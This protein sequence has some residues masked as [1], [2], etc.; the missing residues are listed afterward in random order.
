MNDS[1][2]FQQDTPTPGAETQTQAVTDGLSPL[3]PYTGVPSY[4]APQAE[5]ARRK[6]DEEEAIDAVA[7]KES[8]GWDSFYAKFCENQRADANM[9][10]DYG[11]SRFLRSPDARDEGK[12][13]AYLDDYSEKRW[14]IRCERGNAWTTD[15]TPFDNARQYADAMVGILHR[16]YSAIASPEYNRWMEARESGNREEMMRL[17]GIDRYERDYSMGGYAAGG[18]VWNPQKKSDDE[19]DE[20]LKSYNA[21][22]EGQNFVGVL[23]AYDDAYRLTDEE[24][25]IVL[26][27]L[28]HGDGLPQEWVDAYAGLI[29]EDLDR[30]A[31]IGN[32]IDLTRQRTP[33]WWR[34]NVL[35]PFTTGFKR[36]RDGLANFG[37]EVFAPGL[38][39]S[40]IRR[41]VGENR[42]F[43]WN[44]AERAEYS[45]LYDRY[46]SAL[47]FSD[48]AESRATKVVDGMCARRL[49]LEAM[50]R[51]RQIRERRERLML[52]DALM[53]KPGA[54]YAYWERAIAGAVSTLPYMATLAIPYA[55]FAANVATQFEEVRDDI[56]AGGGD[57]DEAVGAQAVLA[58]AWAGIEKLQMEGLFGRPL[59]G[60]QRKTLLTHVFETSMKDGKIGLIGKYLAGAAKEAALSAVKESVEEGLQDA[61]EGAEREWFRSHDGAKTLDA[62]VTQGWNGFY[63]SLGTMGI[64]G[65]FGA[66]KKSVT[67]NRDSLSNE[68]IADYAAKELKG[69]NVFKNRLMPADGRTLDENEEEKLGKRAKAMMDDCKRIADGH[70]QD[71]SGLRAALDEISEKYGLDEEKLRP[72]GDYLDLRRNLLDTAR[73][74]D[75]DA[76]ARAIAAIAG[77]AFRIGN[78]TTYDPEDLITLLSPNATVETVEIDDPFAKP[79]APAESEATQRL[80]EELANADRR[81]AAARVGSER[82]AA[83]RDRRRIAK[84]LKASEARD[85][86][87]AEHPKAT[88][89]RVTIPVG[90]S[91]ETRSFTIVEQTDAPDVHTRGF[92]A[93]VAEAMR[94]AVGRKNEDG[95][96]VRDGAKMTVDE[97]LELPSAERGATAVTEDQ[98]MALS[99]AERESYLGANKLKT[100]GDFRILDATGREVFGSDAMVSVM[101]AF[102]SPHAAV[103]GNYTLAHEY[104]HA[105]TSFAR[106]L[107]LVDDA[108]AAVMR[109]LFGDPRRGVD[110]LWN[111]EA[112]SNGFSEYLRGE[113][114][115][116]RYTPEE[117]RAAM[118]LFERIW[119]VIKAIFRLN[120][121]R[122]PVTPHERTRREEAL[123]AAYEAIRSG[124]FAG[125]SVYAGIDFDEDAQE[126]KPSGTKK[127]EAEAR[128][129]ADTSERMDGFADDESETDATEPE[130]EQA[131]KAERDERTAGNRAALQADDGSE[132]FRRGFE[133]ALREAAANPAWAAAQPVR[134]G[135]KFTV[136]TPDYQ[137]SVEAEPMWT[138]LASLRESTGDREVQ[139]RDR[140]REASDEQTLRMSRP[141]VFYPLALFP[142]TVSDRGAPIVG[143]GLNIIS[144]HGRK[145][146]LEA[147]AAEG[148]FS[149]YLDAINAEC[150]RQGL[151]TAPEGMENPVL[152]LRVTGG[153][154]SREK[155]VE[156][157]ERSN[158]SNMLERSG[159]EFAE[160][161][162]RRVTPALMR[163]YRPDASGNL[164]A[165]SNRPFMGAFLREV[166]ATGLTNADGTP[167]A[168]A[169]LRV[170]RALMAAVFGSDERVR[171][172]VRSLVERG[173]EL[174][175]SGLTNALMRSA[176]RL[177][178]MRERRGSFD[179]TADVREAA[180]LYIAW[181]SARQSDPRLTLANGDFFGGASPV[182]AA[183]ARLLEAG[184]FGETLEKYADL[185]AREAEDAQGMLGGIA[186]RRTPLQLLCLAERATLPLREGATEARSDDD[187]AVPPVTPDPNTPSAAEPVQSPPAVSLRPAEKETAP[188]KPAGGLESGDTWAQTPVSRK[189]VGNGEAAALDAARAVLDNPTPAAFVP[190]PL[191]R[192]TATLPGANANGI[193]GYEIREDGEPST[194]K[195]PLPPGAY[196][197]LRAPYSVRRPPAPSE[198]DKAGRGLGI[199]NPPP[200]AD[201]HGR[202]WNGIFPAFMGHKTEMADRTS[203]AIRNVMSSAEREHYTTVVDY[204]GGGG[205]W[206]L[207][208]AL[209]NFP[210][211]NRLLVN[212][213]DPDRLEKI[214]LLHEI[215]GR[216]ADEAETILYNP[217]TFPRIRDL[218]GNSSSPSTVAAAV[219]KA[220]LEGADEK[221]EENALITFSDTL[222][223]VADPRE[224]AVLRAFVDCAS[225]M[226]GTSKDES[227]KPL[228]GAELGIDRALAALREDGRRAKEAADAYKARG[229]SIEYRSGDAADWPDAPRGH[230]VVAVCDPPYYLTA[231]YADGSPLPLDLSDGNWS[232]ESTRRLV[233]A[234]VDSGDAMVYTD[235]VWWN[236]KD[237]LP[238][239]REV[240][241][242]SKFAREQATL[243][244]IINT[245]DH[246][247]VAGRVAGRQETLG[248]QHGH[249]PNDTPAE[250]G[251]DHRDALAQIPDD[252]GGVGG[253]RHSVR[254]VA[255]V[256]E[257]EGRVFRGAGARRGRA[258]ETALAREVIAGSVRHS[259][260]GL[261]T[262]SAA[263]YERPSLHYVG[264]GEGTQ[265]YGWGLYASDRRDYAEMY[266]ESQKN[267]KSRPVETRL[268]LDGRTADEY[269]A[270]SDSRTHYILQD[271][272]RA[273][274][275]G[276]YEAELDGD[277]G[278]FRDKVERLVRLREERNA[279]G[280]AL[281]F[282]AGDAD[283]LRAAET[284]YRRAVREKEW[285]DAHRDGLEFREVGG[286]ASEHLYEQTWFTDRAPGDESHLLKWYE[287]VSDEQRRWIEKAIRERFKTVDFYGQEMA[288]PEGKFNVSDDGVSLDLLLGKGAYAGAQ[289]SG[290]GLYA[291]MKKLLGSPRAASEFLARV[292]ID[293]VKYPA[294]SYG[295]AVKDGDEAG[296]NYV[297]FRDDNVRV[298]H[299][300]T[301]GEQ[302]Y[303]VTRNP[304]ARRDVAAA[305]AKDSDGHYTGAANANVVFS[306]ALP[307][308]LV[309]CGIP[310]GRVYTRGYVLRKLERE[311][312]LDADGIMAVARAMERP[313]A[314]LAD[315]A[316]T[317]YVILTDHEARDEDGRVAPVMVYL[318]PDGRG[319]YIASAYARS[320]RAESQY[321]N[322]I[323]AGNALFVDKRKVATLNLTGEVQSSFES[324]RGSDANSI[325]Y[326]G[327]DSQGGEPRHRVFIDENAPAT[328]VTDLTTA[329]LAQRILAG[330]KVSV[331]GAER[332]LKNVGLARVAD[333]AQVLARAQS[334]AE[335]AR[336]RLKSRAEASA[337]E[338]F[339]TLART[340]Q[341]QRMVETMDGLITGSAAASD[342]ET[343]RRLQK[344][345]ADRQTRELL[346]ANG[347]TAAEMAVS[348]PVDL[349]R[350]VLA[351][352]E[353]EKTPEERA[354]LEAERKRREEKRAADRA[355]DDRSEDERLA[356][357]DDPTPVEPTD[358]QRARYEAVLNYAKTAAQAERE[359]ESRRKADRDAAE[360]EG[361]GGEHGDRA[362]GNG[363]ADG[364]QPELTAEAVRRFAPVFEDEWEAA[365]FIIEW[366]AGEIVG[367][368]P[369]LPT[370]A[371]MWK[372]PVAVRELKQT[373]ANLLRRLAKDVLGSPSINYARNLADRIINELESDMETRT[374]RAV[375]RKIAQAYDLIHRNA[376]RI[377]RRK[378]IDRLVNGWREKGKSHPGIRQLAGA[379]GRFKATTEEFQRKIDGRTELWARKLIKV[380]EMSDAEL[381]ERE[382]ELERATDASPAPE[383][384]R[385]A[386]DPDT[387]RENADELEIIRKYGGLARRMPGEIADAADEILADLG[388]RRQAFEA[389]RLENEERNAKV[390]AAIVAAV[391]AGRAPR[392]NGREGMLTRYAKSFQ[393]NLQLEMQE[394]VRFCKDPALREAALLAIQDKFAELSEATSRSRAELM[395]C[396]E[397]FAAALK[398]CYGSEE[399][400][401]RHLL[402]ETIPDD[403][404]DALFRQ[405][406]DTVPTFGNLLQLYAATI[407]GDYAEN[408]RIHGRDKQV[409]LM[410]RTLTDADKRFH[411]WAVRW[412]ADNRATLSQSVEAVTGVPVTSPG[413]LYCPV[414]VLRPREG[415]SAEAS[416]WSPIP[417]ALSRRVP[418]TLDFDES[419][420]FLR[421][422]MEQAE[423]RAQTVGYAAIGISLR[424]TF[425]SREVQEAVRRNVG[426]ADMRAVTDH[427]RDVLVQDRTRGD[428]SLDLLNV[429]RRWMAR[430]AISGN[431]HSALSQPASIPVWANVMLGSEQ[432]GLARV[433]HYMTHVDREAVAE[434]VADDGYAARYKLGWSEAV[435]NVILNPARGRVAGKIGWVYDQGMKLSTFAD[436]ACTLWIAQG[437]YRDATDHYLRRGFALDEAKR[438][439]RA[440][441][442][443]MVEATQQSGGV[444]FM[445]RFQ[446]NG[447]L[448]KAV[449]QY[450]TAQLLANN[451]LIHALREAKA[452]TPGARGRLLRAIAINTIVVPAYLTAVG[453]LWSLFMGD[454][455]P[456]E[457]TSK[458]P[459]LMREMLWAMVEN[460]TAPLF[461]ADVIAAAGVKPLLGLSTWGD[462]G[463]IPAVDS[464]RR[465]TGH[466]AKTVKDVWKFIVTQ[467]LSPLDYEREVTTDKILG[468]LMRL[469]G[470]TAAPVRQGRRWF[471]NRFGKE[472]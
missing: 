113:Y 166:G 399:K 178:S 299:K 50:P 264:T 127:T 464:A 314:V 33:A 458:W 413:A 177:I 165:A 324:V 44:D 104:G 159:A 77:G 198:Q 269:D 367:K 347:F 16:G 414:R 268:F 396:R 449:F 249:Q 438:L 24:R 291:D 78:D 87:A 105:L 412:Y 284:S 131:P 194:P 233:N 19:I 13:F 14:G 52:E 394:L 247:D 281:L 196:N 429:T 389:R 256:A 96:T 465:I 282:T 361:D 382:A 108:T 437:F 97:F 27:A 262:G 238:D 56:I 100:G 352:A 207:Y 335:D 60:L 442:W 25:E 192:G 393:G 463:G 378:L 234:L 457:D 243:L 125:L 235:E 455:P 230:R 142:G 41:D 258:G 94:G 286:P 313:A 91:G 118:N 376:L 84:R 424:D 107:G 213:F 303:S 419:A 62:L 461:V 311:H 209:T 298:D 392:R 153:L 5:A 274:G 228:P 66:F 308:A 252:P 20:E 117:R 325:P 371:E 271:I 65:G 317:G 232:Y 355:A 183:F 292:G 365:Q 306:D 338:M 98:Y 101:R 459:P 18:V 76:D 443:A 42:K 23:R 139:M 51:E 189:P 38:A 163:L 119:D 151:P 9:E 39:E 190:A 398:A 219:R 79:A 425:A 36:F 420:N 362:N 168:E 58:V 93:S 63:E 199:S 216:V 15:R 366:T 444:E 246:F 406:R 285:L 260:R 83:E 359:E 149:E 48:A 287:S 74:A 296:W 330:K 132:E 201:A 263:D 343:G 304:D 45:R 176:G 253:D 407:Q 67:A 415:F 124:D 106:E 450:R 218:A 462:G 318:R 49:R 358:E 469:F 320:K 112:A 135:T 172:M 102:N 180:L 193:D 448:A 288:M 404:A 72:F 26:A 295:G 143:G 161:D 360:G 129:E 95:L 456:E 445:N 144:G 141:G 64:L 401:I 73:R 384:L 261:Y 186:E 332:V 270:D 121:Y 310:D 248:I 451:Y 363:A 223:K 7:P 109:R 309:A 351:V 426:A 191:E 17:A 3:G 337:P 155:L 120:G 136:L 225:T 10:L 341:A 22:I 375:R 137:M 114:D 214:R 215:D 340:G 197:L 200:A 226:L 294:N 152:V 326:G 323:K 242:P 328:S 322:L 11:L 452:G 115:F 410:S 276:A 221:G 40:L 147:V 422:L 32:L 431:L 111:E 231:D 217:S 179:L 305:L 195:K 385:D 395:R 57:P 68:S 272:E 446:R 2:T 75:S 174:S 35:D 400:G 245:L 182:Q 140:S 150:R 467:P 439:A 390:R 185:A 301:D 466:A 110:E 423:V 471:K 383:D 241:G 336:G 470:D 278:R 154:E 134:T 257:G 369:D 82:R 59:T 31:V 240:N 460:T 126:E 138:P 380:I 29:H 348:L 402:S 430:F 273:G 441:T 227:G 55:G 133:A 237:Y 436:K 331:G 334:L 344:A 381:A 202:L 239:T 321:V 259:V 275:V 428:H 416:A 265:V 164:L 405:N 210:N 333:A 300:W 89:R 316:E 453:W 99:P 319:N 158:R 342:P 307:P 283:R 373:A 203:Q 171:E 21:K 46:K 386:P 212:E 54:E 43:Y 297:S 224:R 181:R 408:A 345:V 250:G 434:L 146:A 447:E 184:R 391:E 86:A 122:P 81:I 1:D 130:E 277:I 329:F 103:G 432:I 222:R 312:A 69:L 204:F 157:A 388:G 30:A 350:A 364:A 6:R 349:A 4:N 356:D 85:A 279:P 327:A 379:K 251:A 156:F 167:T 128:D 169:A 315:A 8:D 12:A 397:E 80:R 61:L 387:L 302:R 468:D 255:G 116:K 37:E 346:A 162:A 236:K 53:H 71:G 170:Q 145:R 90:K 70:S 267:N 377:S 244:D 254:R 370:T 417:G 293:G 211:A 354:R 175:L 188:A 435:Q 28:K 206:G 421:I 160:S 427:I 187:Y 266:A 280:S 357:V 148:R 418:H 92:A 220:L 289:I 47:G 208:H 290:G 440:L 123:D 88:V 339:D 353:F 472:D 173:Q 229:G 411:A 205:C 372:S 409:E 368:H 403:V 454:E 433:G 34:D 374:Y